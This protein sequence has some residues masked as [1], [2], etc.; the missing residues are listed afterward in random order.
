MPRLISVPSSWTSK[1]NEEVFVLVFLVDRFLNSH[2]VIAFF[3]IS[4]VAINLV[5]E[6][7]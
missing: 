7:V 2:I 1:R 5:K 4:L 6:L 3:L